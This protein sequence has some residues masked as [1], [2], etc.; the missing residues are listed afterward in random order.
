MNYSLIFNLTRQDFSDRYAGS[1]FGLFWSFVH[2]LA[3]IFIYIVVFSKIMGSRLPGNSEVTNFSIYLVSGLLPWIAFSNTVNRITTVFNDKKNIITKIKLKLYVLPGSLAISESITFAISFTVFLFYY[4][5]VV[6][7]QIY[8]I[9]FV[10]FLIL[11][12]LQQMFAIA[13]GL[14]FAI[15]NVFFRDTKEFVSIFMNFWFWLTPIVWVPSIA[16]KW[17]NELQGSINPAFWIIDGYRQIFV[18][19][20]GI[21]YKQLIFLFIFT[22][23]LFILSARFLKI[24]ERDIRDL[25]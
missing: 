9:F 18:Y 24:F 15:L 7:F 3:L 22:F 5:F 8:P 1:V 13:L 23:L 10:Q 25:I 4:F 17:L 6:N 19:Y 16:P 14:I 20:E 2:P 11:F 12:F 21:G